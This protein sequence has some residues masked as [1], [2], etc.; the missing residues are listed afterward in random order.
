MSQTLFVISGR[1]T[2]MDG[3]ALQNATVILKDSKTGSIISY[4]LSNADG[5]FTL[6]KTGLIEGSY[7]IVV[8]S[9]NATGVSREIQITREKPVIEGLSFICNLRQR[10]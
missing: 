9:I 5:G 8:E 4:S 10:N 7:Q 6:K 1:I 3:Q 2:L